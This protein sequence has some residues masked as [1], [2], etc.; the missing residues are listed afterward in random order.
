MNVYRTAW[1]RERTVARLTSKNAER[2]DQRRYRHAM[3]GNVPYAGV[4]NEIRSINCAAQNA[5]RWHWPQCSHGG[6]FVGALF[7][8]ARCEIAYEDTA[9]ESSR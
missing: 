5:G 9:A 8:R 4:C 3:R 7:V 2:R 6:V 1:K